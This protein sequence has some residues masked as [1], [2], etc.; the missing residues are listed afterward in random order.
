MSTNIEHEDRIRLLALAVAR[1]RVGPDDP[2]DEVLLRENVSPAEFE[3][4]LTDPVFT[5]HVK[6]FVAELEASGFSFAAKCRVLAE[7]V[8]HT[9]HKLASNDEEPA[10]A[11]VKAIENLVDWGGL[12]NKAAQA[13][14][15]GAGAYQLV[16][17]FHGQKETF[18]GVTLEHPHTLPG[19]LSAAA[20][21]APIDPDYA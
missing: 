14:T 8:V 3:R 4:L 2:V 6:T 15:P 19:V 17:N 9:L 12:S 16:I 7:D 10:A 20:A 11:R 1:N 13:Q 5:R 21:D 18:S